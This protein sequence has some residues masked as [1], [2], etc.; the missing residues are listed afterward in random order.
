LYRARWQMKL[1]FKRIKQR[2]DVQQQRCEHW[3]RARASLLAY[4]LCWALQEEE[5]LQISLLLTQSQTTLSQQGIT[6]CMPQP[7]LGERPGD[8]RRDAGG[9]VRRSTALS[10]ARH[11]FLPAHSRV[12][13]QA[14]SVS[15]GP[16]SAADSLVFSVLFLAGLTA[17]G[18]RDG[19]RT[20]SF[21]RFRSRLWSV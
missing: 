17:G 8:Q 4:L 20:S 2:L 6:A 13:A 11:L 5:L 16:S 21:F 19:R 3:G 14:S 1:L 7:D 10:G 18:R 12:L 15:A 9:L